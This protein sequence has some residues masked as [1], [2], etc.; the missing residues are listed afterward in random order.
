MGASVS[1]SLSADDPRHQ[2]NTARV[3]YQF[4]RFPSDSRLVCPVHETLWHMRKIFK[5]RA[6]LYER[7][8]FM[9]KHM[10]RE[11]VVKDSMNKG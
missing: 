6:P 4:V 1:R 8:R 2:S 7:N 9:G 5:T 10:K 3:R 11:A